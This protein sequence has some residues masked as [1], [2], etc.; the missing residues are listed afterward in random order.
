[1]KALTKKEKQKRIR[2]RQSIR[3]ANRAYSKAGPAQRRILIAKDA[4]AQI[5]LKKMD[6][7]TGFFTNIP[8]FSE[9]VPDG[10]TVQLQKL[11]HDP[12][13]PQCRG[14]AL[15]TLFLSSV[16]MRNRFM[17]AEDTDGDEEIIPLLKEFSPKQR[18]LIEMAFEQGNG[19]YQIT[20]R[21]G[22]GG[23]FDVTPD[24][25]A[26]ANWADDFQVYDGEE[27]RLIG[28]LQNII[29]HGEFNP[30]KG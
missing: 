7:R 21:T 20:G 12:D 1:M 30:Y 29:R 28:I 5:K 15:G 3:R 19:W 24:H 17:I 27:I 2:I 26:A 6:V 11:L 4:L 14:C 22:D 18:Q 16:R 8:R 25:K 10:G 23:S 9:L 13:A